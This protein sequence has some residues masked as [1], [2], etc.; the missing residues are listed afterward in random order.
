MEGEPQFNIVKTSFAYVKDGTKRTWRDSRDPCTTLT[1]LELSE[2][3]DLA[4]PP[5]VKSITDE[6]QNVN[7]S[8]VV[9]FA[10]GW[11]NDASPQQHKR[12][13]DLS[14]FD[15]LLSAISKHTGG[16]T[17]GVYLGWRGE[18]SRMPGFHHLTL[19]GRRNVARKIG[20]RKALAKEVDELVRTARRANPGVRILVIGHS[21]GGCLVEKL[22]LRMLTGGPSRNP[23]PPVDLTGLPDLF[24]LINNADIALGDRHSQEAF[25][26]INA[27][28]VAV[29][30]LNDDN[31]ISPWV[32]SMTSD[33]DFD[34]EFWNYW[35]GYLHGR[36]S[37]S[38][39]GFTDHM[40]THDYVANTAPEFSGIKKVSLLDT[41]S[42]DYL[43]PVFFGPPSI[44]EGPPLQFRISPRKNRANTPGYW[45]FR[46][47]TS[48]VE[49]HVDIY[50]VEAIGAAISV[51][52]LAR[53]RTSGLNRNIL[54]ELP[55]NFKQLPS[56]DRKKSLEGKRPPTNLG[57]ILSLQRKTMEIRGERDADKSL[58]DDLTRLDRELLNGSALRLPFNA[59]TIGLLLDEVEKEVGE[60]E[61]NGIMSFDEKKGGV[62]QRRYLIRV[63]SIMKYAAELEDGWIEENRTRLKALL[64]SGPREGARKSIVAKEALEQASYD[65]DC[66]SVNAL[67]KFQ[68]LIAK[69]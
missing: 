19:E 53:L 62:W 33:G 3:G 4:F 2:K 18:K 10:H 27:A 31:L 43:E 6:L 17:L 61:E 49:D 24:I 1:V 37:D 13:K 30:Q 38:A 67:K 48:V 41:V 16:R 29:S 36:F 51:L 45:N 28:P 25:T 57:E 65:N 60:L 54:T 39:P 52:Q 40:I 56:G 59:K 66:A 32:V 22:A 15:T 11:H 64:E 58:K 26:A 50:D 14:H 35:N 20:R 46:L 68:R 63:F 5:Q 7:P 42:R 8:T 69:F 9:L 55:A 12:L 34:N 21:L 23:L 47:P 44:P